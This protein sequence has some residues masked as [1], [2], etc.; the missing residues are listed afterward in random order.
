MT[1]T[2]KCSFF[3]TQFQC[4]KTLT[5]PFSYSLSD[6]DRDNADSLD[7]KP[8]QAV[9][10]SSHRDKRIHKRPVKDRYKEPTRKDKKHL[11]R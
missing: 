2:F 11:Y 3:F 7:I 5:L 9:I 1:N 6:E 8:P 10:R 4:Q